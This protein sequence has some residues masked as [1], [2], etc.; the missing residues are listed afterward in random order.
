MIHTGV[1]PWKCT[2]CDYSAIAKPT[3]TRHFQAIHLGKKWWFFKICLK[4]MILNSF[5]AEWCWTY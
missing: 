4:L 3:L 2:L 5:L 1:K